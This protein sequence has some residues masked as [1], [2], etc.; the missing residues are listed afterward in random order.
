MN[1]LLLTGKFGMGHNSAAQAL[2]EEIENMYG[3]DKINIKTIDICEYLFPKAHKTIYKGFGIIANRY[4]SI[5]NMSY[6]IFDI[7]DSYDI[8]MKKI[9]LDNIRLLI[10]GFNTDLVISTLPLSSRLM[11]VYKEYYKVDL[12]LIT[13]I[14]DVTTHAEWINPNTDIY[15]VATEG[16]KNKLITKGIDG[17]NIYVSGV[18]VKSVFKEDKPFV[19]LEKDKHILIMGGGLGLLPVSSNFYKEINDLEGVKT[20]I[21]TGNN[22]SAYNKLHGKYENIDV[23]G[24][25]NEVDKYMKKAD[26]LISKPG[27]ATLFETIHSELPILVIRPSLNQEVTNAR[28]IQGENIGKIIWNKDSDIL[29]EIKKIIWD[30]NKLNRYRTN[31][32]DIKRTLEDKPSLKAI[33]VLQMRGVAS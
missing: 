11:S 9:V 20:T 6:N 28:Y 10:E 12:P 33:N 30:N 29:T 21:I 31:M 24:Y 23:I 32:V 7:K 15:F 2:R 19:N 27:G 17:S 8:P 25:T 16:I 1:I 26:L 3:K 18:P 22:K 4:T 13:C 14:T 5:Y